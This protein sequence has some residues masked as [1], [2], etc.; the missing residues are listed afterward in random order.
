MYVPQW[1]PL[2]EGGK[3]EI[4]IMYPS[5]ATNEPRARAGLILSK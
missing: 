1:S 4:V 2:D 3:A 5:E